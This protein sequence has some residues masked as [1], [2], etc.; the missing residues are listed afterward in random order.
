VTKPIGHAPQVHNTF[1]CLFFG[2]TLLFCQTDSRH[3]RRLAAALV[4]HGAP[5][6]SERRH[7]SRRRAVAFNEGNAV[8][9]D[10]NP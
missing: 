4:A 9:L 2:A 8:N 3:E 1:A 10:C 7:V 5:A 6:C